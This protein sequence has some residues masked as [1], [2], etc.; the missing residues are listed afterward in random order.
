MW[1][2]LFLLLFLPAGALAALGPIIWGNNNNAVYL[3]T[4]RPLIGTL[5]LAI[6]PLGVI[7]P[8]AC[9]G[10][11]GGGTTLATIAG[12]YT[13]IASDVFILANCAVLCTVTLPNIAIT[14]GYKVSMKNIGT[15]HAVF[16]NQAGQ[17]IDGLNGWDLYP[18]L[19]HVSIIS[20]G[21]KWHVY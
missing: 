5:C 18:N 13:V 7:T 17:L 12:N 16:Q 14:N 19:S 4:N 2:I 6:D 11:G 8:Q 21:G 10:G 1:K 20:S 15:A 9:S 3:P